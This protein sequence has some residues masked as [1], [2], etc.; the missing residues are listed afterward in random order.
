MRE[1]SP[2]LT[3]LRLSTTGKVLRWMSSSGG[4]DVWC[5]RSRCEER[6]RPSWIVVIKRQS[7]CLFCNFRPSKWTT[8]ILRIFGAEHP[9]QLRCENPPYGGLST[10]R[11]GGFPQVNASSVALWRQRFFQLSELSG[12]CFQFQ[13]SPCALFFKGN[14]KH[15][16]SYRHAYTEP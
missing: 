14:R 15:Q 8:H 10:W 6:Q 4:C 9:A 13:N 16:G 7:L 3:Y 2:E 1:C 12:D 5:W 11:W